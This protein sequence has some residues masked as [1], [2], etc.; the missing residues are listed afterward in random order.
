[1]IIPMLLFFGRGL[2]W[3]RGRSGEYRAGFGED[4]IGELFVR[5]RDIFATFIE[6]PLGDLIYNRDGPLINGLLVPFFIL[7]FFWL[8]LRWRERR[9]LLVVSWILLVFFPA[10]LLMGTIFPRA[11]YPA[12]PALYIAAAAGLSVPVAW[13]MRRWSRKGILYAA[14]AL[15]AAGFGL[16][17]F[18]IYFNEVKDPGMRD[19]R[20]LSDLLLHNA[21]DGRFTFVAY[22]P[23]KQW[24]YA[25]NAVP[26]FDFYLRGRVERGAEPLYYALTPELDLLAGV[27]GALR[28]GEGPVAVIASTEWPHDERLA[29]VI[30]Q[31]TACLPPRWVESLEHA[32]YMEFAQNSI[33]QSQCY[34]ATL[35][36]ADWRDGAL[37]GPGESVAF[38]WKL[39]TGFP[40]AYALECKGTAPNAVYMEAESFPA[41]KRFTPE[42]RRDNGLLDG[43]GGTGAI[44]DADEGGVA[45]ADFAIT[46]A[47]R[48]AFW[49]RTL[50]M[51]RDESPLYLAIDDGEPAAFGLED[52]L[53]TWEWERA[54]EVELEAGAHSFVISRRYV[55]GRPYP[56]YIDA[57]A[58]LPEDVKPGAIWSDAHDS[59]PIPL[60]QPGMVRGVIEWVPPESGA[61]TCRLGLLDGE[62]LVSL[63]KDAERDV[64]MGTWT[65][66]LRFEIM[67]S[68]EHIMDDG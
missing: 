3:M 56:I 37:Y 42:L 55:G 43:A 1:M 14:G 65:D 30:E 8:L 29:P 61:Y 31:L 5:V 59:G 19:Y 50:R 16:L 28:A 2:M 22:E 21:D 4:A 12:L 10:P 45:G 44:R 41:L 33:E 66:W 62:R 34:G 57:A 35:S 32:V 58:V 67:E 27:S 24:L 18:Y 15:I 25:E 64:I 51:F 6:Q 38:R 49:V 11:F 60:D 63:T 20:Q 68:S 52:N 17:S 26:W 47:G 13:L 53:L 48:Y 23:S 9:A 7:G 46:E 36:L 39:S 40:T 54:A